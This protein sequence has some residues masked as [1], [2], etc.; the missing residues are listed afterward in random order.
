MT[1]NEQFR[2]TGTPATLHSKVLRTDNPVLDTNAYI[3]LAEVL[4]KPDICPPCDESAQIKGNRRPHIASP[5]HE[6]A[7]RSAQVEISRFY[8]TASGTF[9]CNIQVVN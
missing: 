5:T 7:L 9:S 3:E 1:C 4:S 2:T 6:P 8:H